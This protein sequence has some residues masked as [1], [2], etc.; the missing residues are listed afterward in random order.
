MIIALGYVDDSS[1]PQGV[2]F[3]YV[4]VQLGNGLD[5]SR[6]LP[7]ARPSALLDT[8]A[9]VD[10][11]RLPEGAATFSSI[12]RTTE[13]A[14]SQSYSLNLAASAQASFASGSVSVSASR[15]EELTEASKEY[16]LFW[17]AVTVLDFG[18]DQLSPT[19][20]AQG[21][22]L[23]SSAQSLFDRDTTG[24]PFYDAYGTSFVWRVHRMNKILVSYTFRSFGT[25]TSAEMRTKVAAAGSYLAAKAEATAE[26]K[27]AATDLF[28]QV[29][30]EVAISCLAM[31]PG[32]PATVK[33][34]LGAATTLSSSAT[35]LQVVADTVSALEGAM[36]KA[37]AAITE[38]QTLDYY[39]LLIPS[40]PKMGVFSYQNDL[41]TL[42][43]AFI[44]AQVVQQK[45]N[46]LLDMKWQT[47]AAISAMQT[48]LPIYLSYTGRMRAA[49][50]RLLDP[51]VPPAQKTVAVDL[52][53]R[54]QALNPDSTTAAAELS[55]LQY[56]DSGVVANSS[57]QVRMPAP[58][59]ITWPVPVRPPQD[60]PDDLT[61]YF[62][63]FEYVGEGSKFA[64]GPLNNQGK[65]TVQLVVDG[66]PKYTGLW[67]GAGD[68]G[69]PATLFI[70]G[71][72]YTLQGLELQ[73]LGIL[74]L[75]WRT[76]Y[77]GAQRSQ[78]KDFTRSELLDLL[79]GSPGRTHLFS[80]QGI[81]FRD[82][83]VFKPV[84]AL[85]EGAAALGLG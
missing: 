40:S 78:Q 60:L 61:V 21:F 5:L 26:Q 30:V 68:M 23:I 22:R 73:Q 24:V 11:T 7:D 82:V 49:A 65:F 9:A 70:N 27:Q 66:V 67:W 62:L 20:P 83:Q 4:P 85:V 77:P 8:A 16:V 38:V 47:G 69:T 63:R 12:Y 31:P 84:F 17:D 45:L 46:L 6:A 75:I 56:L 1:T 34:V 13:Q 41:E 55:A 39:P 28:Q 32:L 52:L 15:M 48:A 59:A 10:S 50:L 25:M 54:L 14:R 2:A 81:D 37:N 80:G 3:K 57:Q 72:L 53:A 18:W 76:D 33:Q 58:S 51:T 44:D 36:T 74:T 19:D 64:G 79:N 42:F 35:G 29:N 43:S 71:F